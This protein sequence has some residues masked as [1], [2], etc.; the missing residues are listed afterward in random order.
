MRSPTPAR[1]RWHLADLTHARGLTAAQLTDQV[2]AHGLTISTSQV[3]RW[4]ARPPARL[5]L[6]ALAVLCQ[7]LDCTPNDLLTINRPDQ[8]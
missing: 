8:D 1:V 3:Y 5:P 4:L 6:D 7:V 2:R